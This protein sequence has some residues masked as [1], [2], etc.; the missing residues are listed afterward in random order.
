MN[1]RRI[2]GKLQEE[3]DRWEKE[4]STLSEAQVTTSRLPNGWSIKDLVAHL[5]AWQQV[6]VARL[7]AGQ[8]SE[9]PMLPG[10]LEGA[11]PDAEEVDALNARIYEI[12]QHEPWAR[13]HRAW[14]DGFANVLKLGAAIPEE[15]LE[16][17]EKHPWLKGYPLMAVLEGTYE[18]HHDDHLEAF[19]AHIQQ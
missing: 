5:M 7:E 13:V 6:T 8:R 18:H 11:D 10:W 3:F 9:E 17:P 2:L 19:L 12:Y 4:L 14:R 15:D 1:K 16:N